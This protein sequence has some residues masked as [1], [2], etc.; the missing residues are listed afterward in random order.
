MKNEIKKINNLEELNQLEIG[1]NIL[2]AYGGDFSPRESIFEGNADGIYSF[3][4]YDLKYPQGNL[5]IS[6]KVKKESISFKPYFNGAIKI[7]GHDLLAYHPEDNEHSQ[8]LKLIY[9]EIKNVA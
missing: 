5:I 2:V 3:L 7:M 6:W 4:D 1:S 9:G 8:R